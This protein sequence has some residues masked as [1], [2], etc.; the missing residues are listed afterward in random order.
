MAPTAGG[1][2]EA[3]DHIVHNLQKITDEAYLEV[4][5]NMGSDVASAQQVDAELGNESNSRH[6][7]ASNSNQTNEFPLHYSFV[8]PTGSQIVSRDDV[9][10]PAILNSLVDM[11]EDPEPQN[12]IDV[13]TVLSGDSN[14]DEDDNSSIASDES[15]DP[16][17]AL[18]P[19]EMPNVD[20]DG[21]SLP[22][23]HDDGK[24]I[25]YRAGTPLSEF[26]SSN[27]LLGKAFPHVF[28]LGTAYPKCVGSLNVSQRNHLL[29]QFT[30]IP[31]KTRALLG[32]LQDARKRH[33]VL[34]AVSVKVI[35]CR[36]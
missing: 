12:H 34:R 5:R 3:I 30:N 32:Y 14:E 24:C 28:L 2:T 9:R 7:R 17:M 20:G 27:E 19:V 1:I 35:G 29:K 21:A 26:N 11:T 4:E 10:N 36:Q 25:S 6:A 18:P 16:A 15:I 8:F 13:S 22:D 31:G 33:A 23:H